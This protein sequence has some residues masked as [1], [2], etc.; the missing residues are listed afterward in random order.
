MQEREYLRLRREIQERCRRDLESLDRVWQLSMESGGAKK[1][2]TGDGIKRGDLQNAIIRTVGQFEGTFTAEDMHQK[3][4]ETEPEIGTKAKA[5]SVSSAL[6]RMDGNEIEV[7]ERGVGRKRSVYK[8]R[9][10]DLKVVS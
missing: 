10:P 8:V 5:T 9:K 1:E 2:E 7:V 3:I 4:K 6:N